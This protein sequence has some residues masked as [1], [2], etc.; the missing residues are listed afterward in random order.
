MSQSG[1]NPVLAP[2]RRWVLYSR[3]N[4]VI[5]VVGAAAV[6]FAIGAVVGQDPQPRAAAGSADAVGTS[7]EP[8]AAAETISYELDEVSESLVVAKTATWAAS[9]APAT[10]MAYAHAF[11]DTTLPDAKWIR[12]I[13]RYTTAKPGNIT[14]AARPR[15]P[16]IILGPTISTLVDG[17]GGTQHARVTVPTQ[18][19]N[20]HIPVVVEELSGGKK[21]WVVD[22]PLPTLDLSEV[23]RIAPTATPGTTT[24]APRP[25][26]ESP[27]TETET[28]APRPSS[29][30]TQAAAPEP[31]YDLDEPSSESGGGDDPTPVPGPIPIP[32]LDTPIPGQR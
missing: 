17:A 6:L 7:V 2:I 28:A 23:S 21:R 14:V 11:V 1:P 4:L 29:P 20:M 24:S 15:T 25:S 5:A 13:G 19:G 30:S 8:A 22:T 9:S 12:A 16:V 27:T 32:D 10:A 3:T 31:T 18:A 26:A